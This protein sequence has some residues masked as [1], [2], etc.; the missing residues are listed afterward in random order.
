MGRRKGKAALIIGSAP[1]RDGRFLHHYY[2]RGD[3][4]LCADGGRR[5]A[6]TIGLK[7]DWYVGD[8]DSGGTP[9]GLPALV[10]PVE[11]DTTDLESAV[12]YALAQGYQTLYLCGCTG[13]RMDHHLANCFLLEYI[14]QMGAQGFLLDEVNE[15]TYLAPGHY[16]IENVPAC[17]YLG[18]IPLDRC[19]TG[20]TLRGVK[21]P[22]TQAS[23]N[24]ASALTVSNEILPGEG[25]DITIGTG[26]VL[27]VRSER[28][29]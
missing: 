16:S 10:L 26:A 8:G 3:T 14:H 27:L 22:L 28:L 1:I 20:I 17:K 6:E 4:V 5:Q 13:G 19:V 12:H 11:K 24:R 29:S 7:P 25:A 15:I 9:E 18:L 21:Y 2:E 23:L